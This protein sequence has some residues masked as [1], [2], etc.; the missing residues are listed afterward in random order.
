MWTTA[1]RPYASTCWQV[2]LKANFEGIPKW[3]RLCIIEETDLKFPWLVLLHLNAA[4][5]RSSAISL[6]YYVIRKE[7]QINPPS[8]VN[9]AKTLQ[10]KPWNYEHN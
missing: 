2:T 5:A 8:P 7:M 6:K 9:K 1:Q 4:K 10:I 3:E